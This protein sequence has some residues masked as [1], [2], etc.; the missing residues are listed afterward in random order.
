M[1]KLFDSSEK[2]AI[3][4]CIPPPFPGSFKYNGESIESVIQNALE[5]ASIYSELGYQGILIQNANDNPSLKRAPIETLAYMTAV[6]NSIH[7]EF[8]K[9]SLG[10]MMVWDG[11]SSLAAADAS[12]AD[13]IRVEH[14][15]IGAEMIPTGI[16]YGQCTEITDLRTRIHSKVA[17]LADVYECHAVQICE[18][19]LERAAFE[20]FKQCNAD[21]LFISGDTIV[22]SIDFANRVRL[23]LP[24]AKLFLGNGSTGDNVYDI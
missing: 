16:A 18:K 24:D 17:V 3:G 4:M 19:S 1:C 6:S 12:G 7:N 11:V 21:G 23:S 10:V 2:I 20:A 5:Q 13:F 8:P 22:Q 9:M 15:Y 14:T